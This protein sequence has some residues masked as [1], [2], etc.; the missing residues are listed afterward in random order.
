MRTYVY[1]D[2][3]NLYFG[4]VKGTPY[5]WLDLGRLCRILLPRHRIE[6]IKYFTALLDT[7]PDDLDRPRRQQQYLRA[8]RTIPNLEIFFGH[9]LTHTVQ[10]MLA[11]P[12]PGGPT[13]AEVI[14]TDEKGS[15]VNLA[16]HLLCDGFRGRFECAVVVSGD[17]DLLAPVSVVITELRLPVGVINPQHKPCRVLLNT[18]TFY[19]QIRRSVL[20]Q[21]QFPDE[22]TDSRGAFHKPTSWSTLHG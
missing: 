8:L 17:S 7:R 2:A 3:F 14:R 22:L 12:L 10:M 20:A 1:I 11:N 16:T 6:K 13:R 5:K 18:A 21:C 9:F 4:A 19:K 15:D